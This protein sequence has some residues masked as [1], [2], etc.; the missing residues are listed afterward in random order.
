M[1]FDNFWR[2]VTFEFT[3]YA[4]KPQ[5]FAFYLMQIASFEVETYSVPEFFYICYSKRDV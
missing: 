5:N 1:T 3:S 4:L 2:F